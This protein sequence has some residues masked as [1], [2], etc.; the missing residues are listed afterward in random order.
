MV[1]KE[2]LVSK[3]GHPFEGW[4]PLA[5]VWLTSISKKGPAADK[6]A[7][8]YLTQ[9]NDVRD[10]T[11]GHWDIGTLGHKEFKLTHWQER[12]EIGTVLG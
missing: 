3:R 6:E 5:S 10:G 11:L 4:E 8:V 2:I 12:S 1:E 7:P 9:V